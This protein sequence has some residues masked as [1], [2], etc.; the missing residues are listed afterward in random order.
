MSTSALLLKTTCTL[1]IAAVSRGAGFGLGE[2]VAGN[3]L[4]EQLPTLFRSL[5]LSPQREPNHDLTSA[6]HAAVEATLIHTT[7]ARNPLKAFQQDHAAEWN[8]LH[9]GQRD[10]IK[11]WLADLTAAAKDHETAGQSPLIPVDDAFLK[12]LAEDRTGDTTQ[13]VQSQLRAAL[14]QH[15]A[16]VEGQ[17]DPQADRAAALFTDWFSR[18][19]GTQLSVHFWEQL[20]TD[21]KARPAYFGL[22]AEA[23]QQLLVEIAGH[24][25]GTREQLEKLSQE[26][27]KRHQA[28]TEALTHVQQA[29]TDQ[30]AALQVIAAL[31]THGQEKLEQSLAHI[32]SQLSRIDE[33]VQQLLDGYQPPLYHTQPDAPARIGQVIAI[34]DLDYRQR[35]IPFQPRPVELDRLDAFLH[36][37]QPFVWW[38]IVGEGG[39]GKSR[40]VQEVVQRCRDS[41]WEAGFLERGQEWM[42]NTHRTW[43]P[44]FPTLIVLDYASERAADLLT[45][46]AALHQRADQLRQPVRILL[47]DRPGSVGPL[48]SDLLERQRP[49]ADGHARLAALRALWQPQPGP[50]PDNITEA[51]LLQ[52]QPP[53]PSQWTHYF[54][55]THAALGQ[56]PREWPAADQEFWQHI[57]RISHNGR[58]LYLQMAA[59]ALHHEAAG[60]D[61]HLTTRTAT[62]LLDAILRHELETRW[63]LILKAEAAEDLQPALRRAVGFVTL[64]RG[65]DTRDQT[66]RDALF[67]AAEVLQERREAFQNAL[68]ALL[69]SELGAGELPP[70]QPDLLGERFF[71]LGGATPVAPGPVNAFGAPSPQSYFAPAAW[72]PEACPLRATAVAEVLS[73]LLH[74]FPA[75]DALLP[76][77]EAAAQHSFGVHP[78]SAKIIAILAQNDENLPG[79]A[80]AIGSALSWFPNLVH[81][82]RQQR[83]LPP[84]LSAPLISAIT[85]QMHPHLQHALLLP[86]VLLRN[87]CGEDP[88]LLPWVKEHLLP[89]LEAIRPHLQASAALLV[90]QTAVNAIHHYGSS[91]PEHFQA[92]ERWLVLLHSIAQAHPLQPKIQLNLAKGAVNAINH[93]GR[94][95]PEHFPTMER[96]LALL[97]STAQTHPQQPEIQLMLAMGA[98]NAIRGYGS[99]G[100]GYFPAMERW[101]DLLHAT[102]QSHPEQAEIQLQL[103]EGAFNAISPYGRGGPEH[104]AA[105]E[106]WMALLHT[107]AQAYLEQAEIQLAL[108][109]GAVNAL[110]FYGS[111]GS[112][113]FPTME[114]WLD[115]LHATAQAHPQQAEIQL[116][117]VN[118]A[119]NA[120]GCYGNAGPEHFPAMEPWTLLLAV[121]PD[122]GPE[123]IQRLPGLIGRLLAPIMQ[124]A[125][126]AG[127]EVPLELQG[128]F[129]ALLL[130]CLRYPDFPLGETSYGQPITTGQF[131]AQFLPPEASAAA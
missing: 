126:A 125:Q 129:R 17:S 128:V 56:P 131:A 1:G 42:K 84:S 83:P 33:G 14:R 36:D 85:Q 20:K 52:L 40:L 46:L 124:T 119:F 120:I 79:L 3:W 66:Q 78:E 43:Q 2:G 62:D 110:G 7:G 82:A 118:G 103:A 28:V 31:I 113:Y 4:A 67:A 58:P 111:G 24:T 41:G 109:K 38:G 12:S 27:Q 65:L 49:G 13:S 73:L 91:G 25:V 105:M 114:R 48:F 121:M 72:V 94:G 96:S 18:Q 29:R 74:D 115:L 127:G 75:D 107:T 26:Q 104:F 30:A 123:L 47:L 63:P 59:I 9:P 19:L 100:P 10:A 35:L 55:L 61:L 92:M 11:A 89:P 23:M 70:L 16:S 76:V 53:P 8:D 88:S 102:S 86:L 80:S 77:L 15:L 117:Y 51:R 87:E 21:E 99:G 50:A 97:H 57:A 93:S 90:G 34:S 101:L 5:W 22:V 69:P 112:E 122:V 108:A 106:G 54:D 6:F 130:L 68:C 60:E 39:M 45:L 81:M 116:A 44:A 64:T 32:T 98:V 95:G 37:P 71:L